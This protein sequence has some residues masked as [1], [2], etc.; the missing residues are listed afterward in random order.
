MGR[1][2]G[3]NTYMEYERGFHGWLVFF[4]LTMCLGE[5]VRAFSIY[6]LCHVVY[7]LV[8]GHEALAAIASATVAALL[9][10]GLWVGGLYGLLLFMHEDR[11]SPA[12]WSGYLLMSFVGE[13]IF[14]VA[15]AYEVSV[16][17]AVPFVQTLADRVT[18]QSVE[19]LLMMAVWAGYWMRAK[20]VRATYGYAGFARTDVASVDAAAPAA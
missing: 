1:L 16:M 20:R 19:G 17:T 7:E 15:I 12:Y 9:I 18:L 8:S 10:A 6:R 2:R 5:L 4:F 3:F 14:F 11:R 13:I